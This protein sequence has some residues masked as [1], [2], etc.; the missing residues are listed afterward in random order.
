MTKKII[1]I[2]LLVIG[3]IWIIWFGY[4]AVRNLTTSREELVQ[5]TRTLWVK[6]GLNNIMGEQIMD[7]EIQKAVDNQ[8]KFDTIISLVVLLI[9]AG[10][11]FGGYSL[12]KR[13]NSDA[14]FSDVI[15]FD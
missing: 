1:G 14:Q 8:L 2:S 10:I 7:S 15:K 13:G 3:G 11:S 6:E 5:K 12:Y 4:E 9:G